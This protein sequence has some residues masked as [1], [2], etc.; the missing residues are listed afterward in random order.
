MNPPYD[1][2]VSDDLAVRTSKLVSAALDQRNPSP[3]L[4]KQ[5][6]RYLLVTHHHARLMVSK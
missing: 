1:A 6:N 4:V 5:L 3:E 2:K